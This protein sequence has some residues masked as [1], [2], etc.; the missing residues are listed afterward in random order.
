MRYLPKPPNRRR[1]GKVLALFVIMVT[2]LLGMLGLVIDGGMVMAAHRRTQNAADSAALAAA[3]IL[4]RGGTATDARTA[5]Q[6]FLDT[7]YGIGSGDVQINIPPTSGPYASDARFA[8]A[9]VSTLHDN[10]LIQ[11]A[12]AAASQ[13]VS[14]RAVAGYEA[15]AEGEGAIVLDPNAR[16]GLSVQGGGNLRVKGAVIVNSQ[17]SGLDQYGQTVTWPGYEQQYAMTTSNNSTMQADLFLI[18]GGVDT[19]ANYTSYD[20]GAP[21]PLYCSYPSLSPDP[22]RGMPAPTTSNTPSISN[23]T[24]QGALSF[25]N[26]QTATL[27]PGVYRDIAITNGATVTFNPGVYILSPVQNNEGLRINGDCTVVG[28][29]VMFY[30]TGSN[31]LDGGSPGALD[32]ADDAQNALDGPLPPTYATSIPPSTDPESNRVRFATLDINATEA[33]VTF[34]GLNDSSS[35]HNGML[36]FQRRRNTNNAQIQGQA[37]TNVSIGG[38]IYAKWA[39]FSVSGGGRYDA[40]FV[41]GSMQV[42]GTATVT[43]LGTGESFGLANQVFLVE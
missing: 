29:G 21:N 5:A 22:L 27:S 7:H 19:V 43:L 42:S 41:V 15:L 33:R 26:G 32:T 28:N 39:R 12:G 1:N 20:T 6:S 2:A 3:T 23:W 38:A 25:G 17:Y 10:Y 30:I 8:E 37:G 40:Q 11:I 4:H 14:A 18:R 24:R 9:I 13:N 16:P 35:P 31:Y 34:T 36:F